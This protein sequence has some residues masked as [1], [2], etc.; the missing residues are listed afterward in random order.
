MD[1]TDVGI[2]FLD[3]AQNIKRY[4]ASSL[5]WFRLMPQDIGRPLSYIVNDI[6]DSE[7]L[8][9]IIAEC[10]THEKAYEERLSIGDKQFVLAR[11][12]PYHN[13]TGSFEGAI[14]TC[15]DISNLLDS[16]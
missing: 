14:L 3:D 11:V 5:R 13:D 6:I 12:S 16:E 9:Q 15:T 8:K 2:I 7:R 10:K 1:A 4:N